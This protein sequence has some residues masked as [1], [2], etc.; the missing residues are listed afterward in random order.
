MFVLDLPL[1]LND[2]FV[3]S[4]PQVLPLADSCSRRVVE[5]TNVRK[6]SLQKRRPRETKYYAPCFGQLTPQSDHAIV[7]RSS[8][9]GNQGPSKA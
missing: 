6:R 1:I 4:L 9:S 7:R 8:L 5:E 3:S 2:V